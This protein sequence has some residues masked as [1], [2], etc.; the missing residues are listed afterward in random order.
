[1]LALHKIYFSFSSYPFSSSF[2]LY[3]LIMCIYYFYITKHLFKK[4]RFNW[5]VCVA[6]MVRPSR[7]AVLCASQKP[8][9]IRGAHFHQEGHLPQI[10]LS[11]SHSRPACS[12]VF[13]TFWW[14]TGGILCPHKRGFLGSAWSRL[15]PQL[16]GLLWKPSSRGPSPLFILWLQPLQLLLSSPS[17]LTFCNRN[18]VCT[19]EF[20]HMLAAFLSYLQYFS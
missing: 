5:W 20:K 13:T 18:K 2:S 1:M 3:I 8:R 6:I 17:W 4:W 19:W 9:V 12:L 14:R 15:M 7:L 11:R 10:Q 16:H